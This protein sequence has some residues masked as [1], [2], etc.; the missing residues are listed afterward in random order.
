VALAVLLVAGSLAVYFPTGDRHR[1]LR[2][3][4]YAFVVLAVLVAFAP[5]STSSFINGEEQTWIRTVIGW[6][7]LVS[8]DHSS[9]MADW[10]PFLVPLVASLMCFS[11]VLVIRGRHREAMAPGIKRLRLAVFVIAWVVFVW[12]VTP[13]LTFQPEILRPVPD[14]IT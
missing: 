13:G 1:V 7:Y 4:A 5:A 6:R 12:L 9:G 3:F 11:L 8:F 2:G 10:Y 14:E